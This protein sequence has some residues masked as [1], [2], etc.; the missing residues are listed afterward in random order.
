MSGI[1]LTGYNIH[2]VQQ[3]KNKKRQSLIKLDTDERPHSS[4]ISVD[5]LRSDTNV[6]DLS[7]LRDQRFGQK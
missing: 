7:I 5:T 1:F 3:K 4:L 6:T 2:R